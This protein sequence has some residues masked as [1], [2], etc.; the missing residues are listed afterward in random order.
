[1]NPAF[2]G[3]K[4][5]GRILDWAIDQ[6]RTKGLTHI[7]M[8][9]WANNPVIIDYYRSFGFKVVENYTTPDTNELPAHNR[10]LALTLLE[11]QP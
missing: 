7:R 5:F 1:V 8:D 3:Q 9:T 10:N 4:L 6:S 11:Y 2:K